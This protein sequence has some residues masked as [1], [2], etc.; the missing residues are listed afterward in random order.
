M[1]YLL[2]FDHESH[3]S[4]CLS[5]ALG[6]FVLVKTLTNHI[7]WIKCFT[8]DWLSFGKSVPKLPRN[9]VFNNHL[10][11]HAVSFNAFSPYLYYD[12]LATAMRSL[13]GYL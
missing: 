1:W 7:A 10:W 5:S 12:R 6:Y 4:K 13:Y 8:K 2:Q 11:R 9:Y 3:F